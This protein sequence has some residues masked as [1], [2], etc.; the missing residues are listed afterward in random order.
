MYLWEY[1]LVR[2][3]VKWMSLVSVRILLESCPA[4]SFKN[5]SPLERDIWLVIPFALCWCV[6][7][8]RINRIF[9]GTSS[10]MPKLVEAILSKLHS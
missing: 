7:E 9:E 6:W 3:Y 10:P 4:Q 2:F 1:M 8:E 5:L